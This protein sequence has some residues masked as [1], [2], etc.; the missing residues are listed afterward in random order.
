M[1]WRKGM[2][3]HSKFRNV[4]GEPYRKDKCYENVRFTKNAWDGSYC[5]V[6][7]KFLAVVLDTSGAGGAFLVIPLEKVG[8][9][10]LGDPRVAGHQREILDIQWN[11][12]NDHI[13]ASASEDCTIKIWRIP[14][15]GLTEDLLEPLVDLRGH[16]RKVGIVRWHPTANGIIA[17]AAFDFKV[18][19]W[20]ALKA[21]SLCVID[22]HSD[23]IFDL[24]F[25]YDGSRIATTSKDK[26]IRIVHARTGKLLQ[27]FAGHASPKTSH[28]AF[29]DDQSDHVVSSGFSTS[30]SREISLW[31]LNKSSS[32]VKSDSIDNSSSI[33][34]LHYDMDIKV[35]YVAGKGDG[36]IRYYEIR[37][38]EPFLLRLSEYRHASPQKTLGR[39]SKRGLDFGRCE[40]FRFYKLH[41]SNWIEPL[42]MFCPRRSDEFQ[43]DL[44]PPSPSMQP[45]LTA[46][47]WM[48][49]I[50]KDPNLISFKDGH[51]LGGGPT[52]P[53]GTSTAEKYNNMFNKPA[54]FEKQLS[55]GAMSV[56]NDVN[57][58]PTAEISK[59]MVEEVQSVNDEENQ[60]LQQR[61]DD[62]ERE[63]A[64]LK[65]TASLKDD[66]I[67]KLE[68]ELASKNAEI[69]DTKDELSKK[70]DELR[71]ANQRLK[72]K[73]Q[74]DSTD[75]RRGETTIVKSSQVSVQS[76][77]DRPKQL[78]QESIASSKKRQMSL[79]DHDIHRALDD[80]HRE[81]VGSSYRDSGGRNDPFYS[82]SG[83]TGTSYGANTRDTNTRDTYSG[84][85]NTRDTSSGSTKT[86]YR[87]QASEE[88]HHLEDIEAELESLREDLA[89]TREVRHGKTNVKYVSEERPP[90]HTRTVSSDRGVDTSQRGGGDDK[91]MVITTSS[92]ARVPRQD[93]TEYRSRLGSQDKK[94]YL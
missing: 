18:I 74:T 27:Q 46:D 39:M 56:S 80:V 48:G 28:V 40:V 53:S 91:R 84:S 25:N 17:S 7:P 92:Y 24:A 19:I 94:S 60:E 59:S 81:P 35:A 5:A 62:Q 45:A 36:M 51:H 77:P 2:V 4:Y 71:E 58:S 42:P 43:E 85:T 73:I 67:A 44:Y 55:K 54:K 11:P 63:I 87:K 66:R 61:C 26:K 1:S 30:G 72:M 68:R 29:T 31:D 50:D 89:R 20:N 70:I 10:K 3:T 79:E 86:P 83:S 6:N 88:D 49:G 93:S 65:R 76:I 52:S 64:E 13:I 41:P 21:K 12:F 15:G 14:S 82:T 90:G 32:P 9:Q 38:E 33:L 22:C 69:L 57:G 16:Q 75:G 78:V 47:E 37:R 34:M 23:T 8:H